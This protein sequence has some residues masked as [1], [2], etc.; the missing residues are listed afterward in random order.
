MHSDCFAFDL[1]HWALFAILL[2]PLAASPRGAA[3]ASEPMAYA[4]VR[5]LL[6]RH[7][8][9]IEIRGPDGGWVTVCPKLQGRI[10]TSSFA[11]PNGPSLGWVNCDFVAEGKHVP[12]F[13][14]YGGE[15][16]FWLGPEGGQFGLFFSLGLNQVVQNWLTP[17]ELNAGAFRVESSD[18]SSCR[19]S[20][21]VRVT[22]AAETSL[23]LDVQRQLRVLGTEDLK[24][25]FGEKAARIVGRSGAPGKRLPIVGFESANRA[26]NAGP[27]AWEMKSGLASIWTLGQFP[28]GDQTVIILPYKPGSERE[29]GPVVQ[30]D[31]FGEIPADRLKVTPG[32]VLFRGDGEYRA[33]IGISPRRARPMAGSVDLRTGI[34]TLVQFSLPTDPAAHF[35]VNNTWKAL[36][37]NPLTGDVFNSYNDGPP[38]PGA[39]ALG[40]FYELESL[41]PTRPLAKGEALE[42]HHR[43]FHILTD[44][45]T[46]A[47]LVKETLGADLED[48]RSFVR[49]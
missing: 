44:A 31:Y 35:Y 41:S 47:D 34:L 30:T 33:K 18:A 27:M 3:G 2:A 16:R 22:N 6:R 40:G 45:S 15:D 46:A 11:D 20:R 39:K 4:K 48:V 1:K 43:T 5:D 14:N 9:V 13:N 21:R 23:D 42:H 19:L 12:A 25:L 8:E 49:K 37:E 26:T 28:A 38:E 32:A 36:Q 29:L 17:P 7:T 10:M 24:S